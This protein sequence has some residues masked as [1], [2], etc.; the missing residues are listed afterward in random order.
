[1]PE[2]LTTNFKTDNTRRFV[3]DVLTND[4]YVFVS[5]T[6]LSVS[7]NSIRA[8]TTFL[9]GTLFGKKIADSDV[10]F[11][12][13]YF[14]WQRGTVY[15]RYDDTVDLEGTNF[16]SVVGPTN[17]STGDYRVYK[18]LDNGDGTESI[19]A[20][21]WD[22]DNEEQIYDTQDGY[23]WK[24]MYSMT[25]V[26]F[27]AY[28]ALGY[29]PIVGTFDSNPTANTA[30]SP[31]SDI[32]VDNPISNNG[33]KSVF[34][35][36]EGNPVDNN[37]T[38]LSSFYINF[39]SDFGQS[40]GYYVG[41]TILLTNPINNFT[42]LFSILVYTYDEQNGRARVIVQ[43]TAKANSQY[44][45]YPGF[46]SNARFKILPR[47]KINGDGQNAI[48]YPVVTGGSITDVVVLNKG[49]N[50]NNAVAEVV[51]PV[52]DF[53][54]GD[55]N[56]IDVKALIRPVL[57]PVDGHGTNLVD[58][59]KCRHTLLYG[60]ITGSDNTEIGFNNTYSRVGVVK[61]PLFQDANNDPITGANTPGIFDNRFIFT[62]DDVAG[63]EKNEILYQING[64]NATVFQGKV[65]NVNY[66][67][68]TVA[69]VEYSGPSNNQANSDISFDPTLDF[70]RS[71]G[72]IIRINTPVVDNITEPLYV[73]RSG[74]VYYMEDFFPLERT[75]NSREEFKF[76]MEF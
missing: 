54:P 47:I 26:E 11:M 15:T 43:N 42:D 61:N 34:G 1:M 62:T 58:E 68:N 60:Y 2:I 32:V 22:E 39:N 66:T 36:L 12:I 74:K 35:T 13:K 38:N 23:I 65:Y 51:N 73:Q 40:V 57:A 4:Y 75:E 55:T 25:R 24:F 18:C 71:N 19:N 41:Q 63:V 9:E 10:K 76:V 29:V 31:F 5:G 72:Q 3:D 53:N 17:H 8:K 28:N 14:P 69:L 70:R 16:Y 7:E 56:T 67:S 59:L 27:D 64:S 46:T 49:Q 20:P 50:Y 44:S 33:Y 21:Q 6:E 37:N 48:A 45:G 52:Y 30:G